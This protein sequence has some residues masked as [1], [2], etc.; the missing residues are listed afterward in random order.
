[1]SEDPEAV[2]ALWSGSSHLLLA[3]LRAGQRRAL[4]AAFEAKKAK[5]LLESASIPKANLPDAQFGLGTYN[6]VADTV[7]SYVKGLRALLFLPKGDRTLGLNQL[8]AAAGNSHSFALEARTFLITLYASKHERQFGKALE[9]RNLLVKAFPDTIASS[10]ASARLDLSLGRFDAAIAQLTRAEARAR[11]LG[12]VAPVVVRCLELLRARAELASFRPDLAE[13]TV[14]AALASGAG[15]GPSLREDFL[16]VQ[17]PAAR[18]AAGVPWPKAAA[19][20]TPAQDA[21]TFGA[22]ATAHPDKPIL[23]LLAGDAE[24]RAGKA[25]EALD[26]FARVAALVP[27]ELQ[28]ACQFRQGQ[29]DDLLGHRP[30]ALELY[31]RVAATQGFVAKDGAFYR[32]QTPYTNA[33]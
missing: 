20:A 30:E 6:Y 19:G 21:A 33:P 11:Q 23:A 25:Q 16:H 24:L 9:Q 18:Q 5:H 8:S 29:A 17:E 10:Y 2:A 14:A 3:E 28:A 22:L 7:P 1:V 31:K 15:V 13:A 4:S 32:T 12:D 26:W 27:T